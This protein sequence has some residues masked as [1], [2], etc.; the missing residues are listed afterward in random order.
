MYIPT[1]VNTVP[2]LDFTVLDT[3]DN[4]VDILNLYEVSQLVK[5]GVGIRGIQ[6][7]INSVLETSLKT[8]NCNFVVSSDAM[9]RQYFKCISRRLYLSVSSFIDSET[10]QKC[11]KVSIMSE[12]PKEK[13]LATVFA[14]RLNYEHVTLC[15][16]ESRQST[17]I[18]DLACHDTDNIKSAKHVYLKINTKRFECRL[19]ESY[20]D[21][22]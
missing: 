7:R 6:S 10:K 4:V 13:I 2:I 5:E 3:S 12:S 14:E 16:S 18:L 20:L 9:N 1:S 22:D 8:Y 11:S 21:L 15:N 17:L 19:D